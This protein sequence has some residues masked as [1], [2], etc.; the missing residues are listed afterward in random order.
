[1]FQRT[2]ASSTPLSQMQLTWTNC[3]EL[4]ASG[5]WDRI[6]KALISFLISNDRAMW[7]SVTVKYVVDLPSL[8]Q[9]MGVVKCNRE[10]QVCEAAS[11]GNLDAVT[12]LLGF[13]CPAEY[14]CFSLH[15]AVDIAAG[16]GDLEIL[17]VL[18]QHNSEFNEGTV[19]AAVLAGQY[20]C[21]VYLVENGCPLAEDLLSYALC[22]GRVEII[23]YLLA[24]GY[25][26]SVVCRQQRRRK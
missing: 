20:G 11:L 24:E 3:F 16:K 23:Q 10:R 2:A 19:K 21:L 5:G 6:P 18:K 4:F 7:E 8:A 17:K 12:C 22:S 1:M 25:L 13:G 9:L 15:R 14:K 26:E